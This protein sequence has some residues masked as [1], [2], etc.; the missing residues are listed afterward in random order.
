MDRTHGV[1]QG[2]FAP[3]RQELMAY[4]HKALEHYSWVVQG[5]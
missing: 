3:E 2:D 4:C 1:N 5:E